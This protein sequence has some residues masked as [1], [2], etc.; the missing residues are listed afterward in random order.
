MAFPVNANPLLPA[1]PD[2][3]CTCDRASVSPSGQLERE[4]VCACVVTCGRVLLGSVPGNWKCPGSWKWLQTDRTGCDPVPP[5]GAQKSSGVG[6][7]ENTQHRARLLPSSCLVQVALRWRESEK[8]RCRCGWGRAAALDDSVCSRGSRIPKLRAPQSSLEQWAPDALG[9]QGGLVVAPRLGEAVRAQGAPG[10]ATGG[11]CPSRFLAAGVHLRLLRLRQPCLSPA[12]SPPP[13]RREG[14]RRGTRGQRVAGALP[15][16]VP[17]GQRCE[18]LRAAQINQPSTL[19]A[20]QARL[21]RPSRPRQDGHV[22]LPAGLGAGRKRVSSRRLSHSDPSS[23]GCCSKTKDTRAEQEQL[24]QLCSRA[25]AGCG[26]GSSGGCWTPALGSD[27]AGLMGKGLTEEAEAIG[28]SCTPTVGQPPHRALANSLPRCRLPPPHRLPGDSL[29]PD[30]G[31]C[32]GSCIKY[33][34]RAMSPS[35]WGPP[36]PCHPL[37]RPPDACDPRAL[38]SPARPYKTKPPPGAGCSHPPSPLPRPL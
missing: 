29:E 4:Y 22:F 36:A 33:R 24:P 28:R 34:T 13:R 3:D 10:K 31:L 17:V 9:V 16:A 5:H 35:L 21:S 15:G 20:P 30:L 11:V 37:L 27:L 7:R 19:P 26:E 6:T 2:W 38:S 23:P 12:P 14:A 18:R 8:R 1:S 32:H 25:W